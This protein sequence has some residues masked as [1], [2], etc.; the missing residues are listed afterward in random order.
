[1]LK[2]RKP[3]WLIIGIIVLT[4]L[5]NIIIIKTAHV[6]NRNLFWMLIISIPLLIITIYSAWQ[7]DRLLQKYFTDS[8]QPSTTQRHLQWSHS[9]YPNK[10]TPTDLKV[11]IGNDQCSQPYHACILNVGEMED[12][13]LESTFIQARKEKDVECYKYSVSKVLNTYHLA[14]GG[15]IWQ[16]GPDY[17]GCRNEKGHFNSNAFKEIACRPEVKMIELKLSSAINPI[18][19]V[20]SVLDFVE[21]IKKKIDNSIFSDSAFTT[22]I[23]AEGMIHF[24]NT[25]RDLSGGKPIGIRLCINDKKEFYQICHAIQK[26][27]LIPDFI[28]IEGSFENTDIVHSNKGFNTRTSLYEAILFVSQTLHMYGLQNKIKV[29][30]DG[31]I[32]SCFDILKVLAL[33]ADL[34]CTEMPCCTPIKYPVDGGSLS[35]HYKIQNVYDFHDRLMRDTSKLMS[36]CGFKSVSDITLSK[37]FNKLDVLHSKNFDELNGLGIYPPASVKKIYTQKIKPQRPMEERE[38]VGVS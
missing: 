23:D 9:M 33:G 34:V 10:I 18:Y 27:Q 14:A 36:V 6:D 26:A 20:N 16:I 32:I 28:V 17:L 38:K 2:A 37:F 1:M 30:A 25:L 4:L 31:K 22:F 15:L 11:R 12:P 3:A 8:A 21:P 5:L 19:S 13:Y 29:I 7:T 35:H 24:V